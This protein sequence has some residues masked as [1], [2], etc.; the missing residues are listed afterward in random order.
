M[1]YLIF[2]V[3]QMDNLLGSMDIIIIF[4]DRVL[5][6][7]ENLQKPC[8][9]HVSSQRIKKLPERLGSGITFLFLNCNSRL[10]NY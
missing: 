2:R 1:R 10:F 3:G 4:A 6:T 8:V 5:Y 9:L 7:L